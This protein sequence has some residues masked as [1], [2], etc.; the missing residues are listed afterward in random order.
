MEYLN[1]DSNITR[2]TNSTNRFQFLFSVISSFI[3]FC[4]KWNSWND[5]YNVTLLHLKWDNYSKKY[6][7]LYKEKEGKPK[8]NLRLIEYNGIKLLKH[9]N[10]KHNIVCYC[11]VNTKNC[12]FNICFWQ[13]IY[14]IFVRMN[15][16][17]TLVFGY[18]LYPTW[19]IEITC[20]F[21]VCNYFVPF[22]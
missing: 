17:Y 20:T 6:L 21:P 9:W 18:M 12:I 16:H 1:P 3:Q 13:N 5:V 11:H 14:N 15:S 19:S 10:F 8:K 4:W 22:E 2:I 7:S